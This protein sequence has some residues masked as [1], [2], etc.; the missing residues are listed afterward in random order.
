M[1]FFGG[2]PLYDESV[3]VDKDFNNMME[4]RA[5]LDATREFILKDLDASIAA[6][7]VKWDNSNYGRATKVQRMH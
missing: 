4:P 5:T 7:P 2:V 6:L 1:N 3:L